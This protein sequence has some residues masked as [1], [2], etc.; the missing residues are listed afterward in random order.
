MSKYTNRCVICDCAEL[1]VEDGFTEKLGIIQESD[2]AIA[3]ATAKVAGLHIRFFR[4][5]PAVSGKVG[6]YTHVNF[7]TE[8]S[9]HFCK[10]V[11]E[12]KAQGLSDRKKIHKEKE[13]KKI[14][15]IFGE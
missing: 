6:I 9:K 12:Y 2:M 14:A 7:K 1:M 3:L 13:A 8:L 5:K 4:S 15:D 10:W 11:N